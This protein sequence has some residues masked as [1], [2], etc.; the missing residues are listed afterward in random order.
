MQISE[1]SAYAGDG[2]ESVAARFRELQQRFQPLAV[3]IPDGF[4][5]LVQLPGKSVQ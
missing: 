5:K 2:S 3:A 4:P 1:K